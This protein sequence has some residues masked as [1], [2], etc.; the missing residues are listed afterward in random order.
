M[1]TITRLGPE[2]LG[3]TDEVRKHLERVSADLEALIES[4]L[5]IDTDVKR[6][7]TVRLQQAGEEIERVLDHLD[8]AESTA[9][10]ASEP[11]SQL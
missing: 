9:G 1:D 10:G 6:Q 4:I 7:V 11:D 8:A 3:R 5:P 2:F